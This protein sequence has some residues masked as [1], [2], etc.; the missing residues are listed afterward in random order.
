MR[1]TIVETIYEAA[2]KNPSIYFISGDLGHAK[3][4]EFQ[5][6]LRD[7]YFNAGMAEQ[8]IIGVAAG[9]ALSGMKV[10]VYSIVPFITLR[11]FE[12]IKNDICYHNVDVTIVG[13]GGGFAYGNAG[14]THYSIEE[15][16]ALRALPNMKIICPATPYET[17]TLT[18]E[19][20]YL[21]GP[22]Y[23]RIGRGKE[24]NLE[25]EYPVQ[26]GKA[27]IVRPGK[28]ATLIVSGP[29]MLEA[30][31]AAEMLEKKEVSI[32]VVN[33][34]TLKPLDQDLIRDRATKRKAIFTLEEHSVIGGLGGAV[35]ETLSEV[36]GS[37]A[38][39]Y[40]FGVPD[41]WP[42]IFGSQQY[43]RNE[44]GISAEKVA[45]EIEKIMEAMR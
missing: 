11:C 42:K 38:P 44:M 14:A 29:I 19:S 22:T 45:L 16:A 31:R 17:K 1:F 18:N 13:I 36:Q 6:K 24:P 9:L 26:F 12:Q 37:R 25:N 20:I 41:K 15:V 7:Q 43:L 21:G 8:N 10:F 23:I 27:V 34:H 3:T 4:K 40:R 28:D 30:L 33:M 39:L 35:A 2:L 5:E 32:E